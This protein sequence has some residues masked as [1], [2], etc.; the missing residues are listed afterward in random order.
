M[1]GVDAE[2]PGGPA[3]VPG[4]GDGDGVEQAP[5][6]GPAQAREG[7]RGAPRGEGGHGVLGAAPAPDLVGGA[8]A[9]HEAAEPLVVD[10]ALHAHAFEHAAHPAHAGGLVEAD[11]GAVELLLG[12][13]GQ[14]PA[15]EG[16]DRGGRAGVHLR[17]GRAGLLEGAAVARDEAELEGGV[18]QQ[19]LAH[20]VGEPRRHGRGRPGPVGPE[21]LVV[22]HGRRQQPV[23]GARVVAGGGDDGVDEPV[24]AARLLAQARAQHGAQ[25]QG[26]GA[27][28]DEA[29]AVGGVLHRVGEDEGLLLGLVEVPLAEQ[30]GQA[31]RQQGGDGRALE[32]DGVVGAA[33]GA[34]VLGGAGVGVG[35]CQGEHGQRP[36]VGV[37][38]V[39]GSGGGR[40]G[41]VARVEPGQAGGPAV[42]VGVEGALAG[43]A[44]EGAEASFAAGVAAA[45]GLVLVGGGEGGAGGGQQHAPA[46]AP[47]AA[48][49]DGGECGGGL[50][51]RAVIGPAEARHVG[52]LA[53]DAGE[54]ADPQVGLGARDDAAEGGA[55]V[56]EGGVQ[57]EDELAAVREGVRGAGQQGLGEVAHGGGPGRGLQVGADEGVGLGEQKLLLVGVPVAPVLHVRVG[58]LVHARE[59]P[60][61]AVGEG[62]VAHLV[63]EPGGR[64]GVDGDGPH[65]HA[66]EPGGGA[67]GPLLV[68]E[69][70]LAH[71]RVLVEVLAEDLPGEVAH[72]PVGVG[73][74]VGAEGGRGA[75]GDDGPQRVGAVAG[76]PGA[77]GVEGPGQAA[78]Q[79]RHVGALGAVVGVELVEHEVLERVGRGLPEALVVAAQQQLVEHL[80][81]GEQDV[82]RVVA[83]D[84]AVADEPAVGDP[85]ARARGVVAGVEAG[86]DPAQGGLG[87]DE[88]GEPA[89]LVVGESVHRVEDEGL[90]AGDAGGVGAD[91]VVED[92]DEEGLGLAR[93]GAGDDEGGLRAAGA[94]RV[95][96]LERGG[97]VGVG[98][99]AGGHPGQRV[100]GVPGR[101]RE[102]HARAQER[103]LEDAVG[104]VGEEGAQ[105]RLGVVVGQREGGDE[106]VGERAAQVAGDQWRAEF[107]HGR[108]FIF[109]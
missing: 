73:A 9:L 95:E 72:G 75:D 91:H 55:Q 44:D 93:A 71:D 49:V 67:L 92:G 16:G 22:G 20:R 41:A 97:L 58:V 46:A 18:E 106:V 99:E 25:G 27:G 79:H 83:D 6:P 59:E 13:A 14:H 17:P 69:A 40:E 51:G 94:R 2:H 104:R 109:R 3:G 5:G 96:P 21:L 107:G 36:R 57:V 100:L 15:G 98:V 68:V 29:G 48:A 108:S 31:H 7:G 81:V 32:S 42:L 82:G 28:G 84:P 78:Q 10:G 53:V 23:A 88:A 102:G 101:G 45:D 70:P 12:R 89:G 39:V 54:L 103:P 35:A 52:G 56:G 1:A 33:A 90:H 65:A 61:A 62:Q 19:P 66:V 105:A 63:G 38:G 8:V 74:V 80:V 86:P 4:L 47:A 37:G 30:G 77:P 64:D 34:L 60:A 11:E 43:R 50:L 76:G 85:R 26:A 87:G 24:E